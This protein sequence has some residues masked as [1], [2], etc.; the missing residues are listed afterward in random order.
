MTSTAVAGASRR[1]VACNTMLTGSKRSALLQTI[2]QQKNYIN[3]RLLR[4]PVTDKTEVKEETGS[5]K[6]G[7]GGPKNIG[8]GDLKVSSGSFWGRKH[9][10]TVRCLYRE[11]LR[12]DLTVA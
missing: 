1:L 10:N 9:T 11:K 5:E 3:N 2:T 6:Q 7:V 12:A 8:S 4:G